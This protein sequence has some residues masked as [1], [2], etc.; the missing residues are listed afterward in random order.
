MSFIRASLSNANPEKTVS[1]QEC[2]C[3]DAVTPD[4]GVG[5]ETRATSSESARVDCG[6]TIKVKLKI[7]T[8]Q[9]VDK[10]SEQM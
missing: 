10:D 2:V 6:D 4:S 3:D 9:R 7:Q 1:I 8:V 5:T